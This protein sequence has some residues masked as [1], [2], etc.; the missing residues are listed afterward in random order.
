MHL[1][2]IGDTPGSQLACRRGCTDVN[3]PTPYH[4]VCHGLFVE[5]IQAMF[6]PGE[7]GVI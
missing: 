2:A 5:E 7:A 6:T 1:V 4:R 3:G